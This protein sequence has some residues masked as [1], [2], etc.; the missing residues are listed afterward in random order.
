MGLLDSVLGAVNGTANGGN[1]TGAG[2]LGALVGTLA[3]NPQ[4]VQAVVAMLGNDGAMGGLSGLLARFQQAGLG[5]Q[6]QSWIGNGT[7]LPVSGQQIE[8]ALGSDTVAGVASQ[9]GTDPADAASQLSRV[10]PELINR[11]TPAGQAPT[12]G[13]GNS[14]ELMGMLG[15]MLGKR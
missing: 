3:S 15:G 1:G 9:L 5:E 2:G 11:L 12:G 14:T 13:L 4:V 8:Q 10:L 7:N 6:I